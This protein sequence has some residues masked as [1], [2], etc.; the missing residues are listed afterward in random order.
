MHIDD[1]GSTAA[2]NQLDDHP[3]FQKLADLLDQPKYDQV[4]DFLLDKDNRLK[5]KPKHMRVPPIL[6]SIQNVGIVSQRRCI[7]SASFLFL[8][9]ST[10]ESI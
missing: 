1:V 5:P 6:Q 4:N 8:S 10:I 9:L 7:V 2:S 3:H